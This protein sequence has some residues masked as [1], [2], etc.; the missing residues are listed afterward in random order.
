[1]HKKQVSPKK[2]SPKRVSPKKI[3]QPKILTQTWLKN[4]EN[5]AHRLIDI[6]NKELAGKI[7][8]N[9]YVEKSNSL[10]QQQL[11]YT[12]V[13]GGYA[14]E[15]LIKNNIIYVSARDCDKE[16]VKFNA[17]IFTKPIF[18]LKNYKG[19]WYGYDT[20]FNKDHGNSILIEKPNN[21]YIY[22]GDKLYSFTSSSPIIDYISP[23]GNS[24]VPYPIAY[25]KENIYFMLDQVYVA[26][27]KFK[28]KI[29]LLNGEKI[30][31]EFYD[32]FERNNNKMEH[33][34][35]KYDDDNC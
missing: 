9:S 29:N 20:T 6:R 21:E 10:Y 25:D 35:I 31:G 2:V 1:M 24:Q 28:T 13:N 27:N 26:R 12:L 4:R 32:N 3:E 11:Y 34:Y 23:V 16:S 14:F 15:I 30:Y 19:Y 17:N 7:Y 33:L 8:T 5:E 18:K 22:I